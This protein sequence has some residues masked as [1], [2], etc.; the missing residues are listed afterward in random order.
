VSTQNSKSATSDIAGGDKFSAWQ[1]DPLGET[2]RALEGIPKDKVF[3]DEY[4]DFQRDL[5]YGE[6]PDFAA[7]MESLN[8]LADQLKKM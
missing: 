7:A 6:K 8:A 5:V 4:A 3:I 2:L 1:K